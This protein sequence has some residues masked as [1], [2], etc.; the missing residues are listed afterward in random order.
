MKSACLL[1]FFIFVSSLSADELQPQETS[2]T[3]QSTP[4]DKLKNMDSLLQRELED[5]PF[6]KETAPQEQDNG[7]FWQLTKTAATLGVLLLGFYGFTRLVKFRQNLPQQQYAAMKLLYSFP[8]QPGRQVQILE[9]AGRLYML[10][11]TETGITLLSEIQEKATI[12]RIKLDI[13]KDK[14]KGEPDF[15]VE[16]SKA[17]RSKVENLFSNTG[18]E[19][20]N[21]NS[22]SFSGAPWES[23]RSNG[24][25]RLEGLRNQRNLLRGQDEAP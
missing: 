2:V 5:T 11:V 10:G 3:E 15:M 16:L 18:N 17:M 20:T 25:Q 9:M 12:D 24:G 19:K 8:L 1:L 23:W 6:Q 7:W 14:D 13:D 4:E 21:K 22:S